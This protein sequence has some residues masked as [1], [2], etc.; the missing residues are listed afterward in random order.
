MSLF[1]TIIIFLIVL[2]VLVFVHELGHFLMAKWTNTRVDAFAIGFKPTIWSKKVGETEYMINALPI[3]GYVSIFGQDYDELDP[4]NPDHQRNFVLKKKW[5]QALIM[6]GGILYNMIFAF[7]VFVVI[8]WMGAPSLGDESISGLIDEP[9]TILQVAP[10]SAASDAGFVPGDQIQY[11]VTPTD[12][13]YLTNEVLID[14][15]IALIGEQ[16]TPFI[17]G[18]Q[19]TGETSP[20][21]ITIETRESNVENS[22]E[23]KRLLGVMLGKITVERAGFLEGFAV[24][25][26]RTVASTKAIAVGLWEL[27]TGKM[28]FEAVSGPVGLVD[29]VGQA[30]SMGFVQ[31]LLLAAI[32]SINL[33]IINLLPVPALD[34]GRLVFILIESITGKRIPPHIGGWVN[35]IGFV[36][37][38]LLMLLVTV[39][40][41]LNLF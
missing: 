36:L 13:R 3:G 31:V 22:D 30:R 35:L 15:V 6:I 19:S 34:G 2:S 1:I 32:I 41:V 7:L 14:D 17:V 9:A 23:S 20:R 28:G 29:V 27:I 25:W 24:G 10:D 38:M 4:E 39:K 12:D 33:A 5:Q 40:D 8:G 21:E 16:D 37:L 18:V 26:Q 11:I